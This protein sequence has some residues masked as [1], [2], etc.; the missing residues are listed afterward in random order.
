MNEPQQDQESVKEPSALQ[1]AA[2][3]AFSVFD[4]VKDF[5]ILKQAADK[6]SKAAKAMKLEID[7]IDAKIN[8]YDAEIEELVSQLLPPEE[9]VSYVEDYVDRMAE[10]GKETVLSHLDGFV[11]MGSAGVS[12]NGPTPP[13]NFADLEGMIGT[14]TETLRKPTMGFPSIIPVG[15]SAS[16]TPFVFA[17]ICRDQVKA[18]LCDALMN[19][20]IAYRNQ[21]GLVIGSSRAARRSKIEKLRAEVAALK[22]KRAKLYGRLEALGALDGHDAKRSIMANIGGRP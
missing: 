4:D 9:L 6:V 15:Q 5:N 17:Y 12:P 2:A 14:G 3:A 1:K 10:R 13:L 21:Q 7:E 11:H 19:H 22:S 20:P 16:V 18:A 8:G